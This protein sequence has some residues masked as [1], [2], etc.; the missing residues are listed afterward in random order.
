MVCLANELDVCLFGMTAVSRSPSLS[1]IARTDAVYCL[2]VGLHGT[3]PL[4][5]SAPEPY[6]YH[7]QPD[8][9]LWVAGK[10]ANGMD[11]RTVFQYRPIA[12]DGDDRSHAV[13]GGRDL[14][15]LSEL[16]RRPRVMEGRAIRNGACACI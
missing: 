2:L 11:V 7:V 12:Q 14:Q 5:T 6:M 16:G 9:S 13:V 3:N 8:P 10:E 15:H 1:F 4:P